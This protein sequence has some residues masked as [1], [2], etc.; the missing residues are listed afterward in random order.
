[1]EAI[2]ET[3]AAIIS[4]YRRQPI[5]KLINLAALS[6]RLTSTTITNVDG[7]QFDIQYLTN[8]SSRCALFGA[9]T[10][11]GG[12]KKFDPRRMDIPSI[13]AL[14]EFYHTCL[15]F[16]VKETWLLLIKASN[17][18]TLDGLTDANVAK[19]CPDA[20]E[21]ILGCLAQTRQNVLSAKPKCTITTPNCTAAQNVQETPAL[22]NKEVH[23]KVYQSSKLFTDNTG[24]FPVR[25]QSGNQY[26]MVA[27]HNNGN[28]I[29]AQPFKTKADKHHI[30][31]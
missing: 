25:A 22:P 28:L 3:K 5:R 17:C 2:H 14:V 30:A 11:K 26:I 31:A 24:R 15:G 7:N 6:K 21:T 10:S 12:K 9:A 16:P 13:P 1:M 29:L 27:Y 19:Y 8:E 23:I 18:D 4:A 20:D